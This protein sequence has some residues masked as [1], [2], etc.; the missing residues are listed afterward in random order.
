MLPVSLSRL[1]LDWDRKIFFIYITGLLYPRSEKNMS[2]KHKKMKYVV[3][4]KLLPV[5][6]H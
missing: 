4:Q 5:H 3:N 1:T 2:T 6:C